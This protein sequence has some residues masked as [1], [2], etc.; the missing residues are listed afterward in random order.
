MFLSFSDIHKKE[1]VLQFYGKLH[2]KNFIFYTNYKTINFPVLLISKK[3]ECYKICISDNNDLLV[4]K[5]YESGG[6]LLC[7]GAGFSY[8]NLYRFKIL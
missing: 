3:M 8:A 5:Y 2:R 4:Q 1:F 7:F 6:M